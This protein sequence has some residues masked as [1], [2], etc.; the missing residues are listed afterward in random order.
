MFYAVRVVPSLYTLEGAAHYTPHKENDSQPRGAD[1]EIMFINHL[2]SRVGS[3]KNRRVR[4][5]SWRQCGIG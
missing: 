2:L 3:D 1:V 5:C 4:L